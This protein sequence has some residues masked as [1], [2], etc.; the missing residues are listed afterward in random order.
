MLDPPLLAGMI[1]QKSELRPILEVG[2]QVHALI[3]ALSLMAM[4]MDIHVNLDNVVE[5]YTL[6]KPRRM[7]DVD[8]LHE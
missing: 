4:N 3:A 1:S 7:Y 2:W 6:K 8:Y 5:R